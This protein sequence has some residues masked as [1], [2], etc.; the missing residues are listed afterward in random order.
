MRKERRE[1]AAQKDFPADK[2][3]RE[4]QQS[5]PRRSRPAEKQMLDRGR[6]DL[7][8]TGMAG[9]IRWCRRQGVCPCCQRS[10]RPLY[11]DY[12]GRGMGRGGPGLGGRGM[13]A[14]G[15]GFRGRR[16]YEWDPGFQG[17][18][19]VR[20]RGPGFEQRGMGRWGRGFRGRGMRG[21]RG[22]CMYGAADARPFGANPPRQDFQRP[23][24]PMRGRGMGRQQDRRQLREPPIRRRDTERPDMPEPQGPPAWRRG[25]GRPDMPEMEEPPMRGRGRGMVQPDSNMPWPERPMQ[26]RG[27]GR[28]F[29]ERERPENGPDSN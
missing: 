8:G 2:S 3:G 10:I 16:M 4:F 24:P 18:Y 15:Q 26:R 22:P 9:W 28:G 27:M 6:Q 5:R 23:V 17:R 7:R 13:G 1:K 11:Q 19:G 12:P 20:G 14:R 21:G 29:P 25:M